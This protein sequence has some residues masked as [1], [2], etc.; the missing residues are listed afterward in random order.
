MLCCAVLTRSA[1]WPSESVAF[2]LFALPTILYYTLVYEQ[3]IECSCASA[4]I[5]QAI[6]LGLA[7][8]LR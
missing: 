6:A 8:V 3:P 4:A 2:I 7:S 1:R 5:A